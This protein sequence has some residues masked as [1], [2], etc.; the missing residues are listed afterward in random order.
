[1]RS[2]RLYLLLF[3]L[4]P[5]LAP[6]ADTAAVQPAPLGFP[7]LEPTRYRAI[8]LRDVRLDADTLLLGSAL[9]PLTVVH[10]ERHAGGDL[11]LTV[12]GEARG[13][14]AF[15]G[16]VTLGENAIYGKLHGP[17]GHR[18][19]TTDAGGAWWIDVPD[20]GIEINRC[21]LGMHEAPRMPST[22][23][24]SRT[25]P[26]RRGG[27]GAGTETDTGTVI[28]LLLI[29]NES[30]AERYPGELMPTRL[31]HLVQIANQVFA[32]SGLDAVL[33]LVGTE[34]VGYR[35]DN[36]NFDFRNDIAL[37][38]AGGAVPGLAG[39]AAVRDRLGADLVIGLRP[40]EIE[41]R[42]SCGIAFFP[43]GDAN[44]GVNVVS[45]GSSS[46]SFCL[47]DVLTHEIGHNLGATH[48]LGAG[49]GVVDP[50][51][52][53]FTRSGRFSTV[54]GS[55]GTG[56]PDRFRGLPM[57]ST[58]ELPCGNEPCGRV[59]DTDNV[60]VMRDFLGEVAAYRADNSGAA[61]PEG[62]ERASSDQDGDGVSDWSDALPFD[63]AER[64]DRD[65][66]G[67]G[68]NAD[69][70]P[71]DPGEQDDTDGDGVGDRRD[72]DDDGDGTED[73]VDAFPRDPAEQLDSDRDGV[74]D[75]AD[76]FPGDTDE[77]RDSD[78]DGIGDNADPDDD[79]DGFP[80]FSPDREDVLVVSAGNGQVLRF[81]ADT[82]ETRGVEVPPWD[83]LVTFQSRLH[84]RRS[85]QTLLY[86]GDSSLRRLDL[87]NRDLLG[88]WVP[89]FDEQDPT[90][91]QLGSGFPVGLTT[92]ELG[93]RV[94]TA[95]LGN[96]T[97]ATFQGA[98][99]PRGE[100]DVILDLGGDEA[101]GDLVSDGEEAF[102]IGRN[103]RVI[104]RV[105]PL[106]VLP[107]TAPGV[108]WL[109]D[110]RFLALTGD[111]RLL[112]SDPGRNRVVA[113]DRDTGEWAG[114][115]VDLTPLGSSRPAGLAVTR[116]N[117]LLLALEDQDRILAFDAGDGRWI[118]ERVTGA[119]L[120][121]PGHL[122]TVPAL[123]DRFPRDATRVLRPN[124][125]LW[126]DTA[127]EGRG[128]DIQVFG[129]RLSV[130]W[131]TY[132]ADGLPTWYLA[133]GDLVADRFEAPLLRF[134]R[135]PDG[136]TGSAQVGD[137][138]LDFDSERRARVAWTVGDIAGEER[139]RWLVFTPRV[140]RV[141]NTGLWG[142]ADG[143]GWGVSLVSQGGT[144]AAVAYLY[145]AAGTPRWAISRP[146]T[147]PPPHDFEMTVS[148]GENL[149][150][151]C[152]GTP[153]NTLVE[154][155]SM[156]IEIE[157]EARWDSD[158]TW[159]APLSGTWFLV[160]TAIQRF[161]EPSVRPR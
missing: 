103:R 118:G 23:G 55:F 6:G 100:P 14:L 161:S 152:V 94:L 35:N 42:G 24:K 44:E 79:G 20:S 38:L 39:L 95:R 86:T 40:H 156:R 77:Y 67:R 106:G 61:A 30:L 13:G 135:D 71:D 91:S 2:L 137:I 90:A 148:F 131:Y 115:L 56:R 66:D 49:G 52:S 116:K 34:R 82:G 112:V 159:P 53:A 120:D 41:Q 113:I 4:A 129:N 136:T 133:A 50:R 154:A 145:D 93:R 109:L 3:A 143:P 150:P 126:L 29:Y 151:G 140:E 15:D 72:P 81:D 7:H 108:D 85:D 132:D 32:N 121:H 28:D 158:I 149:C 160:A 75:G 57:F 5:S 97:L 36:S 83:S 73:A 17:S 51:G 130:I 155:G 68:D 99:R 74:G 65:G 127:S 96:P 19:L 111:G 153:A 70:F 62:P 64:F 11:A 117:E 125:G 46:W 84:W 139:L 76:A 134:E 45:D 78:G 101:A 105:T 59:G 58:P 124:A 144:T 107:L 157:A 98:E 92:L 8:D 138:R 10:R 60:A 54:M 69:A 122:I 147:G 119:G 123:V 141:D 146:V 102:V 142:R 43:G 25:R 18:I 37:A 48:Q 1:M 22:A 31:N 89:P 21:T 104:Y 110:P 9:A 16:L 47:D 33:R 114:D 128:F 87:L 80:E 27:N 26:E 12:R 88:L 63:S